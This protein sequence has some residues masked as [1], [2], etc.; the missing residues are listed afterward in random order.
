[1]ILHKILNMVS[2]VCTCA[3]FAAAATVFYK[4]NIH[5]EH[6]PIVGYLLVFGVCSILLEQGAYLLS[7]GILSCATGIVLYLKIHVDLVWLR[8]AAKLD[9]FLAFVVALGEVKFGLVEQIYNSIQLVESFKHDKIVTAGE[10]MPYNSSCHSNGVQTSLGEPSVPNRQHYTYMLGSEMIVYYLC[11]VLN[12]QIPWPVFRILL[13]ALPQFI[14]KPVWLKGKLQGIRSKL[15]PIY[16]LFIASH[17][18]TLIFENQQKDLTRLYLWYASG[19][20]SVF[21][22][23]LTRPDNSTMCDLLRFPSSYRC[24]KLCHKIAMVSSFMVIVGLAF[25]GWK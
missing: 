19:I 17:V 21:A 8:S 4:K 5:R 14:R 3:C 18:C 9:M 1:M 25:K 12:T 7:C 15:G 6:L 24:R 23:V 20:A 11:L 22:G 2:S 10:M 16:V 13:I